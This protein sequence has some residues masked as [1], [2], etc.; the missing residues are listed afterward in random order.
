MH[1]S[2]KNLSNLQL[3]SS[4]H[5]ITVSYAAVR[6]TNSTGIL[7]SLEKIVDVFDVLTERLD[8]WFTFCIKTVNWLVADVDKRLKFF[9]EDIK[10]IN[11]SITFWV[12]YGLLCHMHIKLG[13]GALFVF[14]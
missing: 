8:P 4:L 1:L 2:S 9:P 5:K 7:F 10:W 14:T 11:L 12:F 3:K 13:A 6:L